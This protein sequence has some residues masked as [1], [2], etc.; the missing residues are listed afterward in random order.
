MRSLPYYIGRA[1]PSPLLFF[2]RDNHI[3]GC[4]LCFLNSNPNSQIWIIS[5][6]PK[7]KI[8]LQTK[9]Y[10][11]QKGII[12]GSEDRSIHEEQGLMFFVFDVYPGLSRRKQ[13][14]C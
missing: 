1:Y 8:H 6:L 14:F 10:P 9:L 13:M 4:Y 2:F 11:T 3:H 12:I 5:Q 7:Q